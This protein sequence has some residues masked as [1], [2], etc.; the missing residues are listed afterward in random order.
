MRLTIFHVAVHP[1]CPRKS[2]N[3]RLLLGTQTLEVE[4][5]SCIPMSVVVVAIDALLIAN[6]LPIW[7]PSLTSFQVSVISTLFKIWLWGW[8]RSSLPC[9]DVSI[10]PGGSWAFNRVGMVFVS[11][12]VSSVIVTVKAII[13]GPQWPS[14]SSVLGKRRA[15][16]VI[17]AAR[18]SSEWCLVAWSASEAA[19][20]IFRWEGLLDGCSLRWVAD[21]W[22]MVCSHGRAWR[23]RWWCG[24]FDE[25][26][27]GRLPA[28][29]NGKLAWAFARHVDNEIWEED[30]CYEA[31]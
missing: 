25:F 26:S 7:M 30:G 16:T 11:S 19:S 1:L 9:I 14:W 18:V 20:E 10:C 24:T 17:L 13:S 12:R 21:S 31:D 4:W 5:W 23:N 28:I 15:L 8:T 22:L 29:V 27:V 6:S 3:L 2:H